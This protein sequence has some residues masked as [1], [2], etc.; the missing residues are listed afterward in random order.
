MH[1]LERHSN[2]NECLK[3]ET[4]FFKKKTRLKNETKNIEKLKIK[5]LF[6]NSS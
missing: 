1:D 4:T 6:E 3:S 5:N 2:L